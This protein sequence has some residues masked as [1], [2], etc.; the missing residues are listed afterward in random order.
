MVFR[1]KV[2]SHGETITGYGNLANIRV[3]LK[4][5]SLRSVPVPVL[6]GLTRRAVDRLWRRWAQVFSK[7]KLWFAELLR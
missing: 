1:Y 2:E 6:S 4:E 5:G 7:I 3:S